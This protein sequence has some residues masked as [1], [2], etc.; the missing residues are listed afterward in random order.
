[1]S[2]AFNAD[3]LLKDVMMD[4]GQR[5]T[6]PMPAFLPFYDK[7]LSHIHLIL[8]SQRRCLVSWVGQTQTVMV[9]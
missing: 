4:L 3:L 2:Y 6:G 9:T 7:A 1:M 8:R 5:C